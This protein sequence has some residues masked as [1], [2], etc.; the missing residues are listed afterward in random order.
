MPR[1]AR[2]RFLTAAALAAIG[3][4]AAWHAR[5]CAAEPA[6][7]TPPRGDELPEAGDIVPEMASFDRMMRRF[8]AKHDPPGA[9]LAVG[10]A[11]RIVYARA[12]GYADRQRQR[13][14]TVDSQFRIASISKPITATAIVKL[15]EAGQLS[16]TTKVWEFFRLAE[17]RDRRWKSITV[18]QLLWHS[19]GFDREASFDPMFRSVQ[20]AKHLGIKPPA[21][22]HDVIVYML[23]QPLDFDPGTRYAYSNFG[24][25][26]LGR[27]IEKAAGESYASYVRK[28]VLE[29]CGCQ[30]LELGR[31]LPG[32]RA[33]RE[34]TYEAEGTGPAVIGP[35]GEPVPYPD[36]GWHLEAM[37]AHGGWIST[38]TDLVRFAERLHHGTP[39]LMR[40]TLRGRMFARP[41]GPLGRDDRGQPS[42]VYYG[43]GWQVRPH[44][45]GGVTHWHSGALDGTSSLLVRRWDGWS[46]AVL[47]NRRN[48]K[49]GEGLT[50][51]ID[52]LLHQA[53]GEVGPKAG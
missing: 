41:A 33:P 53:A 32:D 4:G 3:G 39:P 38:A 51:I 31:T 16:F 47:F 40:S 9:A 18:E 8:M 43:M 49:A 21:T 22:A 7:E 20:I 46:W 11:G 36:G 6:V 29:P 26:L 25:C 2:R 45:G 52:P 17:P 13:P 5:D 19:G 12:F 10:K 48:S 42:S 28:A 30:S 1:Y 24:Y 35:I 50:A 37:D 23:E 27:V 15:V 34:V 14:A 44:D